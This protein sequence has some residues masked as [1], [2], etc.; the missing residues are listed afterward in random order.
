VGEITAKRFETEGLLKYEDLTRVGEMCRDGRQTDR[1][2][3][4]QK[5]RL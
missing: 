1:P 4:R 5:I 3:P 2:M